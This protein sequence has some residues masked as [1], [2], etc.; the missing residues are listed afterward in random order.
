M[1]RVPGIASAAAAAIVMSDHRSA[2]VMACPPTARGIATR[3]QCAIGVTASEDVVSSRSHLRA[4]LGERRVPGEID[5]RA[6]EFLYTG[7]DLNALGVDPRTP[8][9]PVS[10]VDDERIS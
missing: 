4:L 6:V 8:T 10:R 7:S 9:D 5:R 2:H 1:R 3:E